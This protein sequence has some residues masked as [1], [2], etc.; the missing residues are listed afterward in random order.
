MEF[1]PAMLSVADRYKLLVG[2]VTPRPIAVVSSISPAGEPNL[3]PFSFFNAVTSDPMT[4]MFCPARH[5]M[6]REKDTLLNVSPPGEGGTGEFVVNICSVSWAKE[7]AAAAEP[8]DHGVSEWEHV[9][10]TMQPAIKVKPP[11]V[12]EA[13]VAYECSTEQIIRLPSSTGPGGNIVIGRVVHVHVD[14]SIISDRLH[15]DPEA[16]DSVGRLG[17]LGYCTTR[18]RFQLPHGLDALH[19]P[20]DL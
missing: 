2:G 13:R 6:T 4:L 18:Q 16:L 8:F 15:I 20:I 5:T 9:G 17:G 7:M 11:R 1:D 14:D 12:A 3:A 19:T 10:L